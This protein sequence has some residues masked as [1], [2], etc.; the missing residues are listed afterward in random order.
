MRAQKHMTTIDDLNQWYRLYVDG[1]INFEL[2]GIALF[3]GDFK[4]TSKTELE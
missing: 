1:L 4:I 3:R 2:R